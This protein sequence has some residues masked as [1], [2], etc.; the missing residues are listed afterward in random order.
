MNEL[1]VL[2]V[3]LS[4]AFV[5]LLGGIITHLVLRAAQRTASRDLWFLAFGFGLVTLSLLFGGGMHVLVGDLIYG[6]ATRSILTTLGFGLVLY[7]LWIRDRPRVLT[8]RTG[9]ANED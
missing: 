5:L 1:P 9:D 8:I 7:S 4:N 6:V 3:V 2:V